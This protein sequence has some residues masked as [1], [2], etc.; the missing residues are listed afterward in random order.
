MKKKYL[1]SEDFY[2]ALLNIAQMSKTCKLDIDVY[3]HDSG[4]CINLKEL[5]DGVAQIVANEEVA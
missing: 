3:D 4:E 5:F 2:Y 1:V